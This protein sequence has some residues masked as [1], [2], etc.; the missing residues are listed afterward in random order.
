MWGLFRSRGPKSKNVMVDLF[1]EDILE[2]PYY[3]VRRYEVDGIQ[4]L[5]SRTGYTGELGYELYRLDASRHGEQLWDAV[6]E[7]GRLTTW[8]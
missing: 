6:L 8:R 5:V 4:V 7:A 2:L 3:F 1:C